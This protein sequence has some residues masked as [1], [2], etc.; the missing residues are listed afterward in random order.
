MEFDLHRRVDLLAAGYSTDEVRRFCRGGAL[1]VVRR[2]VYVKG[3]LPEQPEQR[4]RVRVRAALEHLSSDTVIS[5][6][7]AAI[8]H[9]LPVWAVPLDK[10]HATR[11]RRQTGVRIGREVHMHSAPLGAGDIVIRD[12]I[13]VTSIERT[14]ADLARSVPFAR[15]VVIADAAA[16][17]PTF[18]ASIADVL[19]DQARWPGICGA[20]RVVAFA[21]R[22]SES[23]GESRS[24][25]A[26]AEAGLPAPELQWQ[27]T[28][29]GRVIGRVDF[30]WPRHAT[31]GE[32][33]GRI[34]YGRVL[35]PGEDP[36]D[37]VFEEKRREDALRA[38]GLT[39]VR[40]TWQDLDDFAA[41]ATRL[42]RHLG[43]RAHP[44]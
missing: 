29:A 34:K 19:R 30:A 12:G 31:V 44:G 38:M 22:R 39:V 3:A 10:V 36:G 41:V 43:H 35:R 6:V 20:R 11:P 14:V 2:G 24:R 21:D 26:I 18:A 13:P 23:V 5:H 4:H 1:S 25:V 16:R 27:F 9:G 32:F 40:W 33:D 8:E 15:A 28:V 7:S 37:T 42:R 17:G